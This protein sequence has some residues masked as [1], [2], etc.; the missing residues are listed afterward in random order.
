MHDRA[1]AGRK[2]QALLIQTAIGVVVVALIAATWVFTLA[3]TDA[4][5]RE[6]E[7]RLQAGL[8]NLNEAVQ[9][10]V[11]QSKLHAQHS[12]DAAVA[13]WSADPAYFD[14]GIWLAT[15]NDTSDPDMRLVQIDIVGHVRT[16][17]QPDLAGQD[18]EKLPIFAGI[19]RRDKLPADGNLISKGA[20]TGEINLIRR[21]ELPDGGYAGTLVLTFDPWR[22]MRD[23]QRFD[24]GDHGLIA[25]LRQ[26]GATRVLLP[27]GQTTAA[28]VTDDV[29]QLFG[30]AMH[31]PGSNW[32]GTLLQDGVQ[33]QVHFTR[34]KD[35]D[36]VLV[37]GIGHDEAMRPTTDRSQAVLI[38]AAVVSLLLGG[39]AV[40]LIAQIGASRRREERL[41]ADRSLIE[42][43]YGEL[44]RAKGNAEAKSA[45]IEATLAGMTDGVMMLDADLRLVNWNARFAERTGVPRDM[46]RVGQNMEVILRAQ[47]QRGEFGDVDVEQEV[48]RRVS[49]LRATRGT[50]VVERVRPDG[51]ATELRRSRL[52]SG[53]MVTLYIDT[54]ARKH[55]A[56]ALAAAVRM[57]E[58]AADHKSRFVA[59]VSHEIRTPLNAVINCLGLLDESDLSASQRRL[60]DTAREAGEALMELVNDILELSNAEAGKLEL[61]P[62][63]FELV[64]LLEGVRAMFQGLAN[65]RGIRLELDVAPDLPRQVRADS[66]RLRQVMMNLVSN[67]AKFSAP[68]VVVIKATAKTGGERTM[69]ALSVQDQGPAIPAEEAAKLFVPFSRLKNARSSGAPGTGLGLAICER[70]TR[71]MGGQIALGLAPSGGND[72]EM[73]LPL[74]VAAVPRRELPAPEAVSL[75]QRPRARI[76]VV[77]DIPANHLVAA[78][79]LRREG[80]RV[81]VAESG[82]AAIAMVQH[83]PYDLVLMDLIMPEMDGL[84][85]T[86]RIRALAGQPCRLPIVALTATTS[87]E[88]RLRCL[89]AGMDDMLGK[90]IRPAALF[91]T[92]QAFL[93][94]IPRARTAEEEAGPAANDAAPILDAGRLNELAHGLPPAVVLSLVEQCLMDMRARLPQLRAALASGDAR[95]I[96]VAAHALSGM[97]ASYGFAA[98]EARMRRIIRHA[99]AGELAAAKLAGEGMEGDL[100]VASE[101][102]QLHLRAAVA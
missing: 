76:L 19:A 65:K 1:S 101:A 18:W 73:T 51:S 81:D 29:A 45:E 74:E 9:W 21:L 44:A 92:V 31:S 50:V 96:E 60:A 89:A 8:T 13:A 83:M 20:N 54:S 2:G 53:G 17:S 87:T 5:E 35:I 79:L 43:A 46:L 38:F 86:S 67:A 10:Q 100:A 102:I 3:F 61:R 57:A 85:A 98:L 14:A 94:P 41:S 26:D 56:D 23:L 16:A 80:F 42:A 66:G 99:R 11:E 84:E 72:F 7:A 48:R 24:L 58:E 22:G 95:A 59:I 97:S 62:S 40:L 90:P 69:L 4:D 34:L 25:L 52:P 55:A 15:H 78:T 88:D 82:A 71:L 30:T 64:P 6:A 28:P 47:A 77:E 68:G 37:D 39:G 36:L 12:L 32:E 49:D 33:R 27:V 91:S 63:V 70:L 75:I 93:S